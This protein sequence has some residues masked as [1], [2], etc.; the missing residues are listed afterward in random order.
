MKIWNTKRIKQEPVI[1]V[2]GFDCHFV[3]VDGGW[4]VG[5]GGGGRGGGG[6]GVGVGGGGGGGW[7][8]GGGG[9]WVGVGGWG[10][11]VGWGGGG[12]DFERIWEFLNL[13]AL[14]INFKISMWYKN[15]IL[16]CMGK[17]FREEFQNF[18]QTLK[19]VKFIHRWNFTSSCV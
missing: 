5:G 2:H 3:C 4:V 1:H 16:Q 19:D 17:A 12:G 18:T 15:H 9:G 13:R 11:G 7:G 8:G 10:G 6:V 14:K